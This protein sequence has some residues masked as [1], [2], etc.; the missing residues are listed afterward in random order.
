MASRS[1]ET[2]SFVLLGACVVLSGCTGKTSNLPPLEI[3]P[4]AAAAAIKAYDSDGDGNIS[5][6]ELK[7]A[8][9]LK[10]ALARLDTSGDGRITADQIND[11][12]A[13]WRRSKIAMLRLQLVVRQDGRPLPGAKVTLVPEKYLGSS[14][15]PASGVSDERGNVSPGISELPDE[16]GVQPGFYRIEVS[17]KVGDRELIPARYNAETELGLEVALDNPKLQGL[18]V[19]VRSR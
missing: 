2:R 1:C 7:K 3:D 5:T 12:I 9:A 14:L 8:P 15:K 16:A 18:T 13:A 17:R 19:D 4:G 6:A 11:R 10:S